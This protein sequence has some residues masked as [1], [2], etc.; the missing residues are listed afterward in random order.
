MKRRKALDIAIVGMACRFPG[1][2]D[3]FAFWENILAGLDAIG[4]LPTDRR[5]PASFLDPAPPAVPNNDVRTR[6]GAYLDTPI[7]FDPSAHGIMPLAEDGCDPETFLVLDAAKAAL[8]DAGLP[9]GVTDSRRVEVIIGRGNDWDRG[10]V[11]RLQHGRIV[12]QTLDILRLLH[13]EWTVAE[14]EEV[15]ADLKGGIPPHG[16][17][18]TPGLIT[19]A[20]AGRVSRGLDLRGTSFDIDAA[21]ASSLVALDLGARALVDRRADLALVGAVSLSCDLDD[22][23]DFQGLDSRSPR[24]VARPFGGDADGTVGGEGV[25]VVVLKRL[26]DAERD[27]DRVYAVL[28]GVGIAGNGLG[29]GL[30]APSAKGQARAIRRAYCCSRVDPATVGLLEGYGL[31]VPAADRAELRALR[32][33]FPPSARRALGAVSS[34]IGH[35]RTAAGM[36]GL[37]KSALALHHRVLPPTLHAENPHPL[38]LDDGSSAVLNRTTRPWIHGE[39]EFPRRAGVNAFDIA[40]IN[41]HAILEEHG[42]SADG[43]TPG[44][45]TRWDSEA[46]L[47]GASDRSTWL[48]LVRALLGW[49]VHKPD[50]TLKDLAYTLNTRQPPYPFRVGLVV[51]SLVDLE[52]KLRALS[53]RLAEPACSSFHDPRGVYFRDGTSEEP[54]TL[55]FLF[56]GEGS[57]YPGMLADLCPHFPEVRALFDTSD[58]I[59]R[60]QGATVLPS[61]QLFGASRTGTGSGGLWSIGTAVNVVL[62][63]QW[64]LYQLLTRLGLKPDAVAGHSSGEILAMAAAGVVKVDAEF[65][66][67]IGALGAVFE[68]L[69]RSGAV[70]AAALL[71]V[72]A[73][74][75][76]VELACRELGGESLAVAM[77]NC[78]HQVVVAGLPT[79]VE[80]LAA[81]FKAAGVFR[82]PLPFSRAYHTTGFAPAV[83]PLREFFDAIPMRRPRLPLYS[84][85]I[86][87]R[88]PDDAEAA[89]ALA[90]A[91]WTRPVAF[92]ET[93]DAMHADG[94]RLFV[95]VGARGNLTGFVED[96]LR[97]RPHFAVAVNLP[98]RSG[99]SQLNHLV[100]A[101]FA[102]GVSI[103]PDHL[104]ARRR[105]VRIDLAAEPK[106]ARPAPALAVG[107]PG[108]RL[109]EALAER[110]RAAH[111]AAAKAFPN[112]HAEE[113]AR[114]NGHASGVGRGTIHH[115]ATPAVSP[116]VADGAMLSYLETMDSFLAVQREVMEAYLASERP[117]AAV[118][119]HKITE[120]PAPI[121]TQ[122]PG[123]TPTMADILL[124]RISHRTGYPREM[125]GPDLDLEGDLG[126]D[127]IKRVEI[128]GDLREGG[129]IAAGADMDH[130]SRCRTLRQVIDA[131]D[132]SKPKAVAPASGP[133]VGEIR[134]LVPGR[135]L[136]AIRRLVAKGD[137][138]AENHTLGSRR[139][140]AIDPDRKGLAVVPFAVMAE[141]LAQAG[142]VLAPG[143]TLLGLRDV[144]AHKWIQYED[145]PVELEIR[146]LREETSPNEVRVELFNRA[147]G[148]APVVDGVVSFGASRPESPPALPFELPDPGPCRFTARELYDNQWLFHGPALQAL[149]HVGRSSPRGI[150]GTLRVLPRRGLLR[151]TEGGA[152]LT[153]AIILDAFTQLLGCWGLDKMEEGD[154]MFPLRM[155][156][157]LLFG[158]DP[159]EGA[160]VVCRMAI[161]APERHRIRAEAEVLRPDGR[162]WMRVSGW[163]DWRFYWPGRY[164]DHFRQPDRFLVGERLPLV[165]EPARAC[166][167]WME[168]PADMGKPV[169]RDVLEVDQLGPIERSEC[170]GL[171]GP[172]ARRTQRLWGRIAAKEAAR[173][174]WLDEGGAPVYPTDLV[175]VPDV[176]GKPSLRS[177]A[178][179]RR[180]DMPA[181]S[182]AHT[183]GVAVALAA[184]EPSTHVGIDVERISA[185]GA[186]FEAL[187]F[188]DAELAWLDRA[189]RGSDRGEWVA[190]FWCAKEATGK[191]TGLGLVA[192]PASVAVVGFDPD[193]KTVSVAPGRE[194]LD[195]WPVPSGAP[196]EVVTAVRGEYAWAWTLGR[197]WG[198]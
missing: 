10:H 107:V 48:D 88:V 149:T 35:A 43:D 187:A 153:D 171:A 61:D 198:G 137:P 182:I 90:I 93:V 126:I 62:S 67:R 116:L 24:G 1:A 105:P 130:L 134:S 54:P 127:S 17:E 74:R 84:C 36:A 193:R 189:A 58:R 51:S 50:A 98:K 154:V 85:A 102:Q 37:I 192:G 184:L 180:T 15:R 34:L 104:Y 78:P 72:A 95:E 173:R 73:D 52:A 114:A 81:S 159:P 119:V 71:A 157:L 39:A 55:A 120:D 12:A 26:R 56:P 41:A 122:S 196:L 186:G 33:T 169:W 5:E 99:L 65:E 60:K 19:A 144:Q 79:E 160:D 47:I 117:I 86:A 32:A 111:P 106:R 23:T 132:R 8:A 197:R 40:G 44:C 13:P 133:W 118:S 89:R 16:A 103:R 165:G 155:G 168:P 94:V 178:E 124:E 9:D 82:E 185:R 190:R 53:A 172:E 161:A 22:S 181:V 14:L 138:V 77:D 176:H 2:R 140:S 136:T 70:P 42:A 91:Q 25:G 57:Q 142:A 123:P 146:A 80:A 148:D 11:A 131:L 150:E 135:E 188:S 174:L 3:L 128:L 7:S 18:T 125:L 27:G 147:G 115:L 177:L 110:L 175:I 156:N 63:S 179:P 76:R 49:L 30:A 167:V 28:R 45:L 141:M 183:E 152:L 64:A 194:L 100:A 31:G 109:S 69:E 108:M 151:I 191:A 75:T 97:G 38:L 112:G 166:A 4:D 162:V 83:G 145:D 20:I 92:R 21:G 46:I 170:R 158:D 68:G 59:A 6:R 87:G 66:G 163:E 129:A 195:A 113:G 101:L 164:R 143:R 121:A 96:T 139:V 29:P